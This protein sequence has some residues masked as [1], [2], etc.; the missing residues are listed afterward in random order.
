MTG[1]LS[2]LHP[3]AGL[4]SGAVCSIIVAGKVTYEERHHDFKD[5]AIGHM[6][7]QLIDAKNLVVT[8]ENKLAF[9][10]NGQETP[11]SP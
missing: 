4:L 8:S 2:L 3:A 5:V 10:H 1:A 7:K 11:L 6:I 9:I